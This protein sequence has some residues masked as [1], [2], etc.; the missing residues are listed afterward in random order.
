[1]CALNQK[2]TI[3]PDL[4]FSVFGASQIPPNLLPTKTPDKKTEELESLSKVNSEQ[5]VS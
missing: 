4:Y 5:S 2:N 1:M 3:F